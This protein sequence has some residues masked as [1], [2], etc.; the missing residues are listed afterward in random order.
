MSKDRREPATINTK[1]PAPG[2]TRP[3]VEKFLSQV[4][5]LGTAV[6]AGAR[7]RL[8]F[9]LDATM[10]RQPTWDTACVLQADMFREAASAGGLDIQLVYF[11]GL[12]ECRA[13]GWVADSG[14]LAAL[15]G[16]IACQG[17]HTQIG[18]VLSH[19][20][21]ENE[22]QRVQALVYVGDAMEEGIDD[23]CAAAG[24]LGLRG[25]PVFMFQEGHDAVA[26]NAYREIAR[27]SG[28]AWCRFDTG[29]A[30][31]LRELL[32]AV[33]AYAAGGRKALADLSAKHS[34]GAQL[35]LSQ[36]K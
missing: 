29:A 14:K 7:G 31:Q 30:E 33:A 11:R 2:S 24:E 1:T 6:K 35:L 4:N 10:S 25:L 28:G 34:R 22:R 12:N 23:L 16:R 20:K 9:A 8:V 3:E 15:M 32:R 27:L 17:G 26:E 18:R 13:S 5:A 36:M 19:A 21:Q